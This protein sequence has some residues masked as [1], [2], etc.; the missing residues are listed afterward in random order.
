VLRANPDLNPFALPFVA[1]VDILER[2]D[3]LLPLRG[4]ITVG[5]ACGKM[6]SNVT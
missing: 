5:K 4:K 6:P 2:R 1:Q 3:G